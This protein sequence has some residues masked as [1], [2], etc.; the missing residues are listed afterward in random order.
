MKAAPCFYFSNGNEG[1]RKLPYSFENNRE[2]KALENKK[3][4]H[5]I[6]TKCSQKVEKKEKYGMI[7]TRTENYY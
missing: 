5:K 2:L 7:K 3:K 6:I 4:R 1:L